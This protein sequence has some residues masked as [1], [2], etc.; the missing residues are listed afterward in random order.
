MRRGLHVD[1]A[2]RK[3]SLRV[4]DV[5]VESIHRFAFADETRQALRAAAAGMMPRLISVAEGAVSLAM[6][7][8]QA[9]ASSQPPPR[10]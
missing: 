4:Y 6:R 7:R 5:T 10:Q 1:E 2:E 9:S 8:S 3:G